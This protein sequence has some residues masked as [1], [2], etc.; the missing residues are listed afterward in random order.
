MDNRGTKEEEQQARRTYWHKQWLVV[1]KERGRTWLI[2]YVSWTRSGHL[3]MPACAFCNSGGRG[4]ITVRNK[5]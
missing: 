2:W 5:T 3:A 4:A 1:S